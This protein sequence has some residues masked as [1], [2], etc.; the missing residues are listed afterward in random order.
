[1]NRFEPLAG[2]PDWLRSPPIKDAIAGLAT[3]RRVIDT[4][5]TVD[6]NPALEFDLT[7]TLPDREPYRVRHRLVVSRQVVHNF[8]AGRNVPVRV[9]RHDPHRLAIG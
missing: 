9:D 1:V 7:V 5:L 4:G 8:R 3:I 2:F 6:D